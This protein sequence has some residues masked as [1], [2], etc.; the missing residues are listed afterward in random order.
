MK[1]QLNILT[2]ENENDI[3]GLMNNK[4]YYSK[5]I[6]D[7]LFSSLLYGESSFDE[8][9]NIQNTMEYYDINFEMEYL[10]FCEQIKNFIL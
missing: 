2:L 8:A 10:E 1:K 7:Q 6:L 4:L 5:N 9:T 3:L